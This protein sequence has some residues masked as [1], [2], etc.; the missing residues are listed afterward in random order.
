MKEDDVFKF[1]QINMEEK[2]KRMLCRLYLQ[3]ECDWLVNEIHIAP[4]R[5]AV[6]TNRTAFTQLGLGHTGT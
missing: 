3:L 2:K 1:T 5:A 4:D 6:V